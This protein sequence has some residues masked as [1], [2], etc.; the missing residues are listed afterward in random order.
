MYSVFSILF[1]KQIFYQLLVQILYSLIYL[2]RY[3]VSLTI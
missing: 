2:V 3:F 1:V